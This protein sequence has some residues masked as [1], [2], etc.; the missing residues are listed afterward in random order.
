MR[1][2]DCIRK[3]RVRFLLATCLR[4]GT[5]LAASGSLLCVCGGVANAAL[6]DGRVW[7]MVSPPDKN[8][9]DIKGIEGVAAGGVVQAS[10]DGE[11][12]TYVSPASFGVPQGASVGSQYIAER[13]AGEGWQTQNISLPM[14]AQTYSLGGKGTPYDA[15]TPELSSGL[16]FG[17]LRGLTGPV[18]S[19]PLGGAPAGYEDYYLNALPVGPLQPLLTRTLSV[20]PKEFKLV[21]LGATPDLSHVVVA[22]PAALGEG[23]VEQPEQRGRSNLYEWDQTTGLFQTVNLLPDGTPDPESGLLFGG[24]GHAEATDHAV[25][26]SGSRVVWTGA[27]PSNLDGSGLYVRVGIGTGQAKTL[28]VDAAQSGASGASHEGDFFTANADDSK[29]FFADTNRLTADST[30]SSGGLGDLYR[31]EPEAPEGHRL[32][33]LTVDNK[34]A[35]GAELQGVLGASEN[36]SYVY[37]VAN[38]TLAPGAE[39]GGNCAFPNASAGATCNL[40]LWHD[41]ETRFI[42]SVASND[43]SGAG[44]NALGVA[45]DWDSRVVLRTARVSHDGTRLLFMSERS[46]TGYD[47]TVSTGPICGEGESRQC[48][49]VFLYEANTNR[50]SCLS[51]NPSG[52]SPV[53]PSS[54][55]GGTPFASGRASY[56]SR[57]LSEG[58]DGNRVFFDSADALVPQDTNGQEDVYEYENGN[59]YL[60]SSGTSTSRSAFVD[61]SENGDDVFFIT[62][63]QLVAQDTDQLV[64]L[65]DARAPHEPGEKVGFPA[66]EPPVVCEEEDCRSPLSSVA[67]LTTFS[68]ATFTGS[69][70]AAPVESKPVAKPTTKKIEPK[71]RSKPKL[72]KIKHRRKAHAGRASRTAK[73]TRR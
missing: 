12:I 46:L 55:P 35:G 72:K 39:P 28:Q 1:R 36:G 27:S 45:F 33:D 47:N 66:P 60:L 8:G 22:S 58:V 26:V 24:G 18:E 67:A 48:E 56:Q 59:V 65:Y 51:C 30:A 7:E 9:G 13:N 70:N 17:G 68:S 63:A 5:L 14:G 10:P 16:V 40:Y 44:T 3:R 53:G 69:G 42:A 15:F 61:A 34:D 41:G 50:L 4:F 71:K 6:S 38:G 2:D 19:P 54:I 73:G 57:V 21:Y 32:T 11:K 37:F 20:P 31:F 43:E 49:E 23:A 29:I 62:R 25:S 64:D 52:A